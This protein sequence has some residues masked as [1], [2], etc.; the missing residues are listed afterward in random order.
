MGLTNT[1]I[2]RKARKK[3]ENTNIYDGSPLLLLAGAPNV[4]KSTLFNTLTGKKQHTGNWTGKTVGSAVGKTTIN[5]KSFTVV[6]LPGC[7]SLHCHSKEE[8][9]AR[10]LLCFAPEATV[11]YVCDALTIERHLPLLFQIL[12]YN[13]RCILFINL[14]DEA[15][16]RG[17]RV[18]FEA[19]KE[20]LGIPVLAISARKK[21]DLTLLGDAVIEAANNGYEERY[22]DAV[23]DYLTD[24]AS[25]LIGEGYTRK[26]ARALSLRYLDSESWFIKKTANKLNITPFLF[27]NLYILST[28]FL[29]HYYPAT[30]LETSK[31]QL[32]EY[33]TDKRQKEAT[34]I[35]TL[36]IKS[37]E[38][39][40]TN[41]DRR[42]D[43]LFLGKKTA[44][45]VMLLLFFFL[46]WLTIS[47]ANLPSSLLSTAF[48]RLEAVLA[49]LFT[50]LSFPPVLTSLL[51]EGVLRV[52]G[53]VASVML[54]PMAI[55]FLLFTFLEDV[56]YLPRMAFCLDS[57][58]KRCGCT[59]RQAL[60]MCM[61]LGC[62]AAGVVGCR[63]MSTR[64]ERI[65]A[66][67][68][69][70]FMPCNGR[71]PILIA[72]LTLFFSSHS[73]ISPF[74]LLILLI[75]SVAATFFVCSL[76]SKTC[77][78]GKSSVFTLELP[79]YRKPQFS[80]ILRES[81]VDRTLSVL[82]RALL[83]AAPMGLLIW[84]LAT[85]TV[86]DVSLLSFLS[87]LL[88][89]FGRIIG[90]DGV[91]L[92]SFLLG[93]PASEIVIPIILICYLST[94]SLV[95]YSSL[96]ELKTVLTDN[97]WTVV[98]AINMLLF[99]LF[100]WP[101]ATTLMTIKKES[102]SIKQTV[103]AAVIPTV[104]GIVL[105]FCVTLISSLFI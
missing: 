18:D 58:F 6:D 61:G 39:P 31:E 46:L 7:Y 89:P 54:P 100:H 104:I 92:L 81:L 86:G 5:G 79:P 24:T 95:E 94:G 35:C 68:T 10:D 40:P 62:N 53:W 13:E 14:I 87:G 57:T 75:L 17:I 64:R 30:D 1:A 44:F 73:L 41:P 42:L 96:S 67:V 99:T 12:S 88:D 20:E 102:G 74:L 63:I 47:G 3:T 93:L 16:K 85:I 2:G 9:V 43:A 65:M 34:R 59:G 77:F 55:F 98:T 22:C 38:K 51:C 56:G 37:V 101:C 69:N 66:M 82:G 84:L 32:V 80:Q 97:G 45:P 11:L 8:E 83:F 19:L 23:E 71:F 60:T 21:D 25:L 29:S 103:A 4:G 70:S 15:E 49:A 91:I 50:H 52:V 28:R 48:A 36:V 72:I 27:S 78:K 33:L 76:L 105:C 26:E 90:L